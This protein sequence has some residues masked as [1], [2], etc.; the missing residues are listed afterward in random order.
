MIIQKR[1]MR[2]FILRF[3]ISFK[4]R[5]FKIHL[6]SGIVH[7]CRTFP[8]FIVSILNKSKIEKKYKKRLRGD[9][10]LVLSTAQFYFIIE[11]RFAGFKKDRPYKFVRT[12]LLLLFFG[13]FNLSWKSSFLFWPLFI[14]YLQIWRWC[15]WYDPFKAWK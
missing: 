13:G 4:V 14:P 5:P 8:R 3:Y 1:L 6:T 7:Q 15:K 11:M 2:L 9:L 10:R 12:F